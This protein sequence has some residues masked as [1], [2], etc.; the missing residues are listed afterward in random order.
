MLTSHLLAALLLP[1][2]LSHTAD[3]DFGHFLGNFKQKF[4]INRER[5]AFVFT[6]EMAF[7]MGGTKYRSSA[8]FKKFLDYCSRAFKTLRVHANLLETLFG[9]MVAAGMPELIK[10][11]DIYYMR[12]KLLL[13]EKESK[14][15]K[16]LNE[17]IENSLDSKY[18]RFDN[19]IHNI[20]HG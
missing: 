5:A 7:V 12:D 18:R 17:E 14:A 15:E 9:L 3:I 20:R 4:G 10:E 8:L 13:H 16:K 2:S 11:T 19:F 1:L 6:P